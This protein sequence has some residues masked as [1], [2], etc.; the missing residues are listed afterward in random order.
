MPEL[1]IWDHNR[2]RA[3][4]RACAILGD[5]RL[6]EIVRGIAVHWYSGDYFENLELITKRFPEVRLIFTEGCVEHSSRNG[7]D[8]TA[9]AEQYAHAIIG[10]LN[11][12]VDMI[13]DWNLVLDEEGGPNHVGNFCDA[14]VMCDTETG[15]WRKNPSYDYIGHFS[16]YI[17]PGAE[18]IGFARY[19]DRLET[20]AFINPDGGIAAVILNRSDEELT[21][22]LR[23][24]GE[25]CD[26]TLPPHS[27]I[28]ALPG[29][30]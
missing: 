16:R 17:H 23:L 14:P 12:G 28:T 19:S 21:V 24:Y 9:G 11:A 2:E 25:L 3:F 6:R 8:R 10:D 26:L 29:R 15:T 30:G 5:D 1:Y 18:R 4:E 7:G 22:I 13:L 20:T 27:I